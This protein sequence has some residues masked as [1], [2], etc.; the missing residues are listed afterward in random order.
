MKFL[1]NTLFL[2]VYLL[3]S[4]AHASDPNLYQKVSLKELELNRTAK[5]LTFSQKKEFPNAHTG[6]IWNSGDNNTNKWRPQGIAGIV[7]NDKKFLAVSWYGRKEAHYSN[8]GVRVSFVDVTNM[9]SIKYRHV[10]LVDEAYNTFHGMHAGGLVYRKGKLHVP[11]TRIG[12]KKIH[13][14]SIDSIKAVPEDDREFFYNY[15]Y[16]LERNS[17]YDVSITP[18]FMSYDWSRDQFVIGTFNENQAKSLQWYTAPYKEK[19][20]GGPFYKKMQGA[21]SENGNLWIACSYGRKNKSQLYYGN[22][23]PGDIPDLSRFKE[24]HYPPGLENIHI[25]LTSDNIWMLTEFGPHE[26]SSN[27]R[28]VFATKKDK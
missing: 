16:I 22:Y 18:S 9:N 7:A 12:M 14:F 26:G 2:T 13:V 10:L 17:S 23:T 19:K 27:N 15:A 8:R 20:T 5:K 24:L 25:S 28:I 11:D 3:A 1:I 21:A 6:F 4:Y